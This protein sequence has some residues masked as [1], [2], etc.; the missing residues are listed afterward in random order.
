ME[1]AEHR[2][3][4]HL[5]QLEDREAAEAKE[6]PRDHPRHLRLMVTQDYLGLEASGKTHSWSKACLQPAVIVAYLDR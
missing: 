6:D 5:G 4:R 2:E 1:V 3:A